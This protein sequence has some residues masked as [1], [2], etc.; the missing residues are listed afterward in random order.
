MG[1]NNGEGIGF[2]TTGT[3]HNGF[4][5]G[6]EGGFNSDLPL[7]NGRADMPGSHGEG[8]GL[9]VGLGGGLSSEID[10]DIDPEWGEH[11]EA[12]DDWDQTNPDSSYAN[13]KPIP[14]PFIPKDITEEKQRTNHITVPSTEKALGH[15]IL[16]YEGGPKKYIRYWKNLNEFVKKQ[17]G[18]IGNHLSW[19]DKGMPYGIPELRNLGGKL[20]G[21]LQKFKTLLTNAQNKSKAKLK[22]TQNVVN[23]FKEKLKDLTK[24]DPF[25]FNFSEVPSSPPSG[26]PNIDIPPT[27]DIPPNRPGGGGG[28]TTTTTTNENGKTNTTTTTNTNTTTTTTTT[29]EIQNKIKNCVSTAL[30]PPGGGGSPPSDPRIRFTPYFN[31]RFKVHGTPNFDLTTDNIKG[32]IT[33]V[34]NG[35]SKAE[36]CLG[37]T[38]QLP[39]GT[40]AENIAVI[41]NKSYFDF[42]LNIDVLFREKTK[43]GIAFRMRDQYNYYAFYIDTIARTKSIIKVMDGRTITLKVVEDGGVILNDWHS[44]HISLTNSNIKVFIYDNETV[45]RQSSEKVIEAYDNTFVEGGV[46]IMTSISSG[47]CFDKFKVQGKIVWTAWVSRTDIFIES[48]TSSSYEEGNNFIFND[49]ILNF[50]L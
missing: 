24:T 15:L 41:K 39:T 12:A 3:D 6:Y 48:S 23:C 30:I 36:S 18:K 37:V 31:N 9:G 49:F 35:G 11:I 28:N 21:T 14:E 7:Y 8:Y 29:T 46:G 44:V 16:I 33:A 5:G 26:G 32:R 22:R 4:Y 34:C 20:K 19:A 1:F 25:N 13:A 27:N 43:A 17:S 45:D 40:L 10:G 2:P 47:F 38:A 50:R 42:D